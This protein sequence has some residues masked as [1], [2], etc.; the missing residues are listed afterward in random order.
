MCVFFCF[1]TCTSHLWTWKNFH[2]V[3][4]CRSTA[5]IHNLL[6]EQ[7]TLPCWRWNAVG[8]LVTWHSCTFGLDMV[9]NHHSSCIALA[10]KT[11]HVQYLQ[12]LTLITLSLSG[13][14]SM[15]ALFRC[16][17]HWHSAEGRC[18]FKSVD[19]RAAAASISEQLLQHA[20]VAA[21]SKNSMGLWMSK[22]LALFGEKEARILVLGL[23]NAGKTTI[24]C[25]HHH[26]CLLLWVP[27]LWLSCC[28]LALQ[29]DCK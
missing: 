15:V 5:S 2:N 8:C 12:N 6:R 22:L 19:F 3:A 24:L 25:E 11:Y 18:D 1:A 13:R 7:V 27:L 20:C 4:T 23:D 16:Q 26:R 17:W 10:Y 21:T 28:C 14:G 9:Q 29:I